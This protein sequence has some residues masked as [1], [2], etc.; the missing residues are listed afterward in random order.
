MDFLLIFPV[1]IILNFDSWRKKCQILMAI[2]SEK[3]KAK[4]MF[5]VI[6]GK[7]K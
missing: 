6:F 4:N 2:F 5:L 1:F 7:L 3:E